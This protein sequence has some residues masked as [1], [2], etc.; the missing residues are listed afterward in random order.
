M[1]LRRNPPRQLLLKCYTGELARAKGS[2]RRGRAF[3]PKSWSPHFLYHRR[4][5][6]ILITATERYHQ[7]RQLRH[8]KIP[9]RDAKMRLRPTRMAARGARSSL[10][11]AKMPLGRTAEDGYNG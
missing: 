7:R 11:R 6:P 4:N 5:I 10:R 1:R 3:T 8:G 2:K 9:A